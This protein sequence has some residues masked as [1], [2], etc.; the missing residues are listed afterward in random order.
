[1]TCRG[2]Y[3]LS[4]YL[5]FGDLPEKQRGGVEEHLRHCPNCDATWQDYQQVIRLARQLPAV[6]LP[7]GLSARLQILLDG[8]Q[9]TARARRD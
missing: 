7:P 9:P 2:F 6:P 4:V 3:A 1:M 8:R 5:A